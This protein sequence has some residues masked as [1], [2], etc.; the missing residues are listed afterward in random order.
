MKTKKYFVI[1]FDSTFTKVEAL[2][3]LCEISKAS[4]SDKQECL[5]KIKDITEQAME[6]SLSFREAL[7]KRVALLGANRSHLNTLVSQLKEKVSE[8][9]KRN[10][11][12][13]Q[14][15][16]ADIIIMSS[17]FKEF[18]EPIVTKYGVALNNIYAN[19]FTFDEQD[20]IIGF[21]ASNPLSEDN[22]K[23]KLMRSLQLDGDVF[24]IGD[25]Y[26]DYE[27]REAGFA[28]KFYAFTENIERESVTEKADHIAPSF[29]EVL[30][31]NN[32]PMSISYPKNR[33]KA[34]LLENV[35]AN[36]VEAFER[37]GYQ[38][39]TFAGAMD[40]EELAERIRGVSVLGIR[41]KT[42]VT[43]KVLQN[44]NRLLSI[45]AFCIGTNQID[46]TACMK[47][48]VSVFNAPYSNTRS[49]VEL[50]IGEIVMLMRNLP[51]KMAA[52]HQGR[53]DKSASGSFEIRGKKLGIIG[54]GNIGSQLSVL[55]EAMGMDVYY[56]DMVEKLA[57][58]NATKCN[59]LEELLRLADVVSLH[60]DGRMS[61]SNF[62]GTEHFN[63]MK[64]GAIFLNLARGFVMDVKA[65]AENIKSGKIAGAGVDVFP[66][67]PKNNQ[68]A[69]I[70]ELRGLPNVI[71]TPHIGGSTL[72]AQQNI[73]NF[74]PSQ[75]ID[76][77]N[78]G[79]TYNSVNFPAI[80]LPVLEKAHR[81]LHI[82]KNVSGILARIN[83]VL[84][85][86]DINIV[87][88]YLKTNE[89]IGYVIT[90]IYTKYNPNVI[91]DLKAIED[92]IKFRILY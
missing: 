86:H 60:V 28:H 52:M 67:E 13:F 79:N 61:N 58:G 32:L 92:T 78:T 19:N 85:Q 84:A 15:N 91:R 51:D 29:D 74:V 14:Q 16:S 76:Y 72:E 4:A 82:H 80:Q 48:G 22:G 57:L 46:L 55:A 20:N 9:I 39:E 12:F 43:A 62:F 59:S 6:G 40:E 44:A 71:L 11:E 1:D 47:R 53:W 68:E 90:D 66:I 54:Y 83:N 69:F 17:G 3:E 34:L 23:V 36:A 63:L 89:E 49:V 24:V 10:K 7:E 25:G 64:Q 35:H 75:V 42:N 73:A 65:L 41:S 8:S 56:Y 77:I 81:L 88:Q 30:Y 37:E 26:T 70:S 31:I 38:V 5:Q 50:A 27:I 2:D 21:D 33:I 45:G 87:G 18:I